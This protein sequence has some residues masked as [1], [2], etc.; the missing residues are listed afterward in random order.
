VSVAETIKRV[1]RDYHARISTLE[2]EKF[3]LE[4]AVKKKDYEVEFVYLQSRVLL[5]VT[6]QLFLSHS[7]RFQVHVSQ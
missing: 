7:L 1:L 5:R 6:A 4:Y 3:D 2:D